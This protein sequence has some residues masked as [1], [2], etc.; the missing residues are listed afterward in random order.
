MVR[1]IRRLDR[2]Q[3]SPLVLKYLRSCSEGE[4]DPY[5]F[6]QESDLALNCSESEVGEY[7][8]NSREST[9][10]PASI[11]KFEDNEIHI[12]TQEDVPE[13][14]DEVDLGKPEQWTDYSESKDVEIYTSPSQSASDEDYEANSPEPRELSIIWECEGMRGNATKCLRMNKTIIRKQSVNPTAQN[15]NNSLPSIHL[16]KGWGMMS[17][18]KQKAL[19]LDDPFPSAI[20]SRPGV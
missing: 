11:S 13:L 1:S 3:S 2:Y 10:A 6:P 16:I 15:H 14:E 9:P 12:I 19:N 5:H 4:V 8:T 17:C 20:I 18:S 7:S